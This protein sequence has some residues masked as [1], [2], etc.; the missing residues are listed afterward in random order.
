MHVSIMNDDMSDSGY[1]FY[2]EFID[3]LFD[4]A[5][6]LD[7]VNNR[8]KLLHVNSV[9]SGYFPESG[10]CD[11]SEVMACYA[12]DHIQ[13]EYVEDFI[14][15]FDTESLE[16]AF[17]KRAS[18]S[19]IYCKKDGA[20]KKIWFCIKGD[21]RKPGACIYIWIRDM[22]DDI[23]LELKRQSEHNIMKLFSGDY[24]TILLINL[25]ND[26]FTVLKEREE[27]HA[28]FSLYTSF[29]KM[30][31]DYSRS[32]VEKE[33]A[34]MVSYVY[35]N[36][37]MISEF[38]VGRNRI[39]LVYKNQ[40]GWVS[41]NARRM[42]DYSGNNRMILYATK[43]YEKER[44]QEENEERLRQERSNLQ[45][46]Y[47][48]L[49]DTYFTIQLVNIDKRSIF[50]FKNPEDSPFEYYIEVPE[51]RQLYEYIEYNIYEAD[52]EMAAEL[53]SEENLSGMFSN[54]KETRSVEY[55][56]Y[57][58]DE[59]QWIN[60]RIQ[61]VRIVNGRTVEVIL[62]ARNI[63]GQRLQFIRKQ[64]ENMRLLNEKRY[65]LE[66]M[67]AVSDR[68]HDVYIVN[69]TNAGARLLNAGYK[70]ELE[71]F[72]D[73]A[74]FFTV[75]RDYVRRYVSR[76]YRDQIIR[77]LEF[78]NIDRAFG[79]SNVCEYTYRKKNGDWI[80][81]YLCRTGKYSDDNK[82]FLLIF[83]DSNEREE[84]RLKLQEA[85]EEAENANR[86]KTAFFA[87]ISHD[88]RTPM[89][90]IL[91]MVNIA[92]NNID[93]REKLTECIEQIY[94]SGRHLL[95][96]I[97]NVLDMTSIESGKLTLNTGEIEL[98]PFLDNIGAILEPIARFSGIS[99]SINYDRITHSTII[100]D[101]LR[102]RQILINI[103]A[104]SLK[105]TKAG[106]NVSIEVDEKYNP[107][108]NKSEYIIIIKDDGVGMSR[109]FLAKIYDPYERNH[110]VTRSEGNGLGMSITR[111]FVELMNGNI[112][113]DSE[114]GMGT[115]VFVKIPFEIVENNT[116]VDNTTV[117]NCDYDIAGMHILVV[118]DHDINMFIMENY[119]QNVGV[120]MKGVYNGREAVEAVS[121]AAD[122][123]FDAV[124]MDIQMPVMN[125]YEATRQ[126]RGI[127]REYAKQL[128]IYALSAN[129]FDEDIRKAIASG[130][131]GHI[132]K[133]VQLDIL[134]GVLRQ[135]RLM[136]K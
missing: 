79:H 29:S 76:E 50:V 119:L 28:F 133:P 86:S 84:A 123:E 115:T 114:Q 36:D 39:D 134:Y 54:M 18:K 103:V 131:N 93:D 132:A 58:N 128:P 55:R 6:C 116:H 44:A 121:K 57:I 88:I 9:F 20:F 25:N 130:M 19:Y 43:S 135:I 51:Y 16:K 59:L 83:G 72:G 111:S 21:D 80:T 92:Q 102:L 108:K 63:D 94:V 85:L 112:I 35:S 17:L 125:G 37:N 4:I 104:N 89:N 31:Y 14:S 78:D 91:G 68:Y 7:I 71:R 117:T 105:Y 24:Y 11:L 122:G 10:D 60:M 61:P 126:I 38:D 67:E 97:N 34:D 100:G 15:L 120:T 22:K 56:R 8:L 5:I 30:M 109:E 75:F 13:S 101:E 64:E 33:Y 98:I 74:D 40:D 45:R 73:G 96:L 32:Y 42:P 106:G 127:N 107:V 1:G 70:S 69:Y 47:N 49:G 26:T 12:G 46:I 77:A 87:N 53:Y 23:G 82:E 3:A 95:Q 27:N 124:L 118:E 65:M 52:R 66:F 81:M 90:S 62:A 41:D 48:L 99:L 136:K 110:D 113:I 2:G 129:A